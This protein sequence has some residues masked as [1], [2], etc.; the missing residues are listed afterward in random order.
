MR[1]TLLVAFA[2]LSGMAYAQSFVEG[3]DTG[4]PGFSDGTTGTFGNS[5]GGDPMAFSSGTWHALNN[6]SPLG[7][8]GW[9]ST[10]GVFAQN[11]GTGQLNANF[12]NTLGGT[13]TID[14]FMMSPVRTFNNGDTISFFT[15]TPAGSIWPDRT[16]LQ[17]SLNG[18]STNVADFSTNSRIL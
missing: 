15:R 5:A 17:L 7:T 3:F 10:N 16:H 1:R 8:T 9:F 13:G 6:S 4:P 18:S 11:S 14:N 12:A 2:A